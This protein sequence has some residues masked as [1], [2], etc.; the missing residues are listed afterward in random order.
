MFLKLFNKLFLTKEIKSQVG[1]LHFR[2]YRL[3]S[4]P[5]VRLYLHKIC[6]ED[7]DLHMH[8]HPWNFYSL[9][10]KGSYY[11]RYRLGPHYSIT[12]NE[13]R[14]PG[15]IVKHDRSDIHQLEYLENSPVWTLV[16]AYGQYSNWGYRIK[17]PQDNNRFTTW[18]NHKSYRKLK[19]SNKL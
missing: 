11:E 10:L 6:K 8:D 7:Q 16:L 2:R 9:I 1:E 13:F 14:T 19:N 15:T 3:F 17:N 18:I 5:W 4:T 12:M